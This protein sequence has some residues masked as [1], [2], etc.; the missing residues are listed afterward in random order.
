MSIFGLFGA[1]HEAKAAEVYGMQKVEPHHKASLTHEVIAGAAAFEAARKYEQ[2][3][4]ANGKPDN[5]ALAKELFAGF[6]GAELDKLV[7][8]KGLDWIDKEKA[9]GHGMSFFNF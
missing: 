2:H 6:L 4:A 3:C 7:E 8:T 9:Q 5:H 1:H